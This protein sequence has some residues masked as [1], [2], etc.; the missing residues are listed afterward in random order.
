MQEVAASQTA[1]NEIGSN[2]NENITANTVLNS[3]T[4]TT[5]FKNSSLKETFVK[6]FDIASNASGAITNSRVIVTSNNNGGD[7]G[8]GI[9]FSNDVGPETQGDTT[10]IANEA[11][12]NRGN[13][14]QGGSIEID[15]I[16]IN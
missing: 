1:I 3:S 10:F 13:S 16:Q 4:A 6:N 9:S 2:A 7:G 14:F 5:E 11:N 15:G 8:T 12:V